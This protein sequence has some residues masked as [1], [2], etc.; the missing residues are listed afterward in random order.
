MHFLRGPSPVWAIIAL[1]LV[2]AGLAIGL[3]AHAG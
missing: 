1:V 3:N 2:L